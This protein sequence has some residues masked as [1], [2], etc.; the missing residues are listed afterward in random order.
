MDDVVE[1]N[2]TVMDACLEGDVDLL[3]QLLESGKKPDEFDKRGRTP[4]HVVTIRGRVDMMELLLL[5]GADVEVAD[6]FGSQPLHLA[7]H[8]ATVQCLSRYGASAL[9]K[10]KRGETPLCLAQRRGVPTEVINYLRKLQSLEERGN[11]PHDQTIQSN[12]FCNVR[13][14]WYDFCLD[15]G[16]EKLVLVLITLLL[17]SLYV[18]YMLNGLVKLID[19]RIPIDATYERDEL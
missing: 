7:G 17:L 12:I 9:V 6:M 10:N 4:L 2:L 18:A 8:Y 11:K 14:T 1:R 15:L 3:K 13:D 19:T 16:I 5:Y